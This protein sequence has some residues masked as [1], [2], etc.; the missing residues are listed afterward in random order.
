MCS[1]HQVLDEYSKLGMQEWVY[2]Y[3]SGSD[4]DLTVR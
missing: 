3:S 1:L 2:I 4:L